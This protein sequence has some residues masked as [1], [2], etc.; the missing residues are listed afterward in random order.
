[1]SNLT[2]CRWCSAQMSAHA[3]RCPSCGESTTEVKCGVCDRIVRPSAGS[4]HE[5]CMQ[6]V[7][8]VTHPRCRLCSGDLRSALRQLIQVEVTDLDILYYFRGGF[9]RG[10]TT[11]RGDTTCPYCGDP[12]PLPATR[13]CFKCGIPVYDDEK[14]TICVRAPEGDSAWEWFHKVCAKPL[15][16]TGIS[17]WLLGSHRTVTIK[18]R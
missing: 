10:A 6:T 4:I 8:P 9:A 12:Q 7:L 17:K 15:E 3:A 5:K 1:M 18:T 2:V 16:R 11:Y 13:P 14:E